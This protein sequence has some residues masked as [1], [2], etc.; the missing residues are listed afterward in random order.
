MA[1]SFL[2]SLSKFF[3]SSSGHCRPGTSLRPESP[4]FG[5]MAGFERKRSNDSQSPG[6]FQLLP[7]K[8]CFKFSFGQRF[9]VPEGVGALALPSSP[10]GLDHVL[11]HQG[12]P[13]PDLPFQLCM[14]DAFILGLRLCKG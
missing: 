6:P 9:S 12:H 8:L 7:E 13:L 1:C 14:P 2:P 3:K 4:G 5:R 10:L 11:P